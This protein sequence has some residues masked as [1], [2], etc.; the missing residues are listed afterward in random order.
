[1]KNNI[2]LILNIYKKYGTMTYGEGCSVLSHSFQAGVLAEEQGL[3]DELILAAFLH[4]IGH[5]C[6]LERESDF[7]KMDGFGIEAHDEIGAIFLEEKSF[8]NKIIAT[9]RNHVNSKRYLCRVDQ[10]YFEQLSDASKKTM[11]FQ[12][13]VMTEEEAR[14]FE[15]TL[16]FEES[17]I[18]RKIDEAAKGVDFE[19]LPTHWNLFSDLLHQYFK[20]TKN[21]S[22]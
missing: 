16:F 9:V 15:Q 4:D 1:M 19:I 5:L 3:D 8:S 20:Q 12:G 10:N 21:V 7:S 17:I 6:P 14:D 22:A 18:I 11:T 2:E 13:G